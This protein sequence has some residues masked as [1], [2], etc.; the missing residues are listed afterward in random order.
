MYTQKPNNINHPKWWWLTPKVE[1]QLTYKQYE[2]KPKRHK[3][4]PHNNV[5]KQNL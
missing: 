4:N 2:S 5:H 1:T 3:Q